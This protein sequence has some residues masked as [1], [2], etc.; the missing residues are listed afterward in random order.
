MAHVGPGGTLL[1]C[2]PSSRGTPEPGGAAAL[3]MLPSIGALVGGRYRLVELLGEGQFGRVY[4]A[5]RTDLAEHH[6]ALKVL[7]SHVYAGRDVEEELRLLS[8]VAHPHIVQL[9]DHGVDRGYV[10]FT[11]PLYAGQPLDALI[12]QRTMT[13]RE[14]YDVFAPIAEGLEVL[15]AVG[16][17][18]QDVKPD[19]LFLASFQRTRFPL[20]LDLGAAAPARAPH[21]VAGTLLYAAPEQRRALL[22]CVRGELHREELDET[23]DTYSLAA[24]LLRCLVGPELFPGAEADAAEDPDEMER[25]LEKAALERA[26]RPLRPGALPGLPEAARERIAEA[27]AGWMALDPRARPGMKLLRLQLGVLLEGEVLRQRRA[28]RRRA[29]LWSLGAAVAVGLVGLGVQRQQGA[30]LRQCNDA[31]VSSQQ[32][33]VEKVSSLD[34][35]KDLLAARSLDTQ[36]CQGQVEEQ[37][38]RL[39]ELERRRTAPDVSSWQARV[40]RCEGDRRAALVTCNADIETLV[41]EHTAVVMERDLLR[42]ERDQL[43]ASRPRG[44]APAAFAASS[45]PTAPPAPARDLAARPGPRAR[46]KAP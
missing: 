12:A 5:E 44:A 6:V 40:E 17:R 10:W 30:H 2:P 36:R 38:S 26:A 20:L 45:E 41:R 19:N 11:M 9:A 22:A 39:Q 23:V 1:F 4:R 34:Q 7:D 14:A 3:R 25:L 8:A 15:H 24:T 43:K 42:S 16:L 32:Q 46:R 29:A 31:L 37:Q 13:P 28:Q 27:L 18:H 33:A 21:P 35:C